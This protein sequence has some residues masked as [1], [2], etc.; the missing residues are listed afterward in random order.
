MPQHAAPPPAASDAPATLQRFGAAD[1]QL[2]TAHGDGTA[3]ARALLDHVELRTDLDVIA[4]TDHDDIRGALLARE[5]HARRVYPFEFVPGI[6]LTTRAGHILALWVDQPLRPFRPLAESIAAVHGAGGLV[7]IPHPF[8]YLTRSVGRRALERLLASPDAE[9]WPDAIELA[10]QT[11]AGR[12]TGARARRANRERYHLAETGGSDAHFLEEVGASRTL[13]VGR[14]AAALRDAIESR[15]TQ[16]VFAHRVSLRAIGARR[17]TAQQV[18][19]LAVT[20][21][22]VLGPPLGRLGARARGRRGARS[23]P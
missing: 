4:V 14:T 11:L 23:Q 15:A 9:T 17:L 7:I 3:D 12:V 21:R 19:G 22:K 2:H 8:S 16:A 1:L 10:N 5:L 18:R 6:E 20:P 13:F